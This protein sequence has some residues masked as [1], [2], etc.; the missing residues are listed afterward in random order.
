LKTIRYAFGISLLTVIFL[1]AAMAQSPQTFVSGQ[2]KDKGSCSQTAPCRTF[3]QAISQTIAGGAVIAMDSATYAPFTVT[4]ALTVEAPFG[5][6]VTVNSGD[7]IDID[8]GATDTVILRGLTINSQGSSG[9]GI[10]LNSAGTL[11]IEHCVVNA[12]TEFGASGITIA[13]AA[14]VFVKD[15]IARDNYNGIGVALG[16]AAGVTAT[17]TLEQVHLDAN[18]IGL[19]IA[20]EAGQ[21]VTGAVGH[22]SASGNAAAGFVLNANAGG[23]I[24]MNIDS[25]LLTNSGIGLVVESSSTS[26]ATAYIAF[27]TLSHNTINGFDVGGSGAIFSRGNNTVSD[28]GPNQGALTSFASQ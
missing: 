3:T 9:N 17:I 12:F 26:A 16:S 22:S 2:G 18:R 8:A 1:G 15:T 19:S 7:G 13:G 20:T 5:A 11:H 23:N 6:A 10:V 14:S 25:C 27:C 24:S 4:K 28:N 21:Q